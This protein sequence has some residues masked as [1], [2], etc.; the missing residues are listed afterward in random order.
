[1]PLRRSPLSRSTLNRSTLRP[2]RP[3]Q[4]AEPAAAASVAEP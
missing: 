2:A 1:M 3:V 4:G